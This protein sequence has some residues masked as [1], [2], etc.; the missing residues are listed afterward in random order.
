[1]F[2]INLTGPFYGR[3]DTNYDNSNFRCVLLTNSQSYHSES[4]GLACSISNR[5]SLKRSA[6]LFLA[7]KIYSNRSLT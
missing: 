3:Y 4:V 7:L 2:D 5:K 6:G 1:M